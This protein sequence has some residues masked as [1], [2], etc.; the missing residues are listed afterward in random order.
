MSKYKRGTQAML[1]AAKNDA[2]LLPFNTVF[3]TKHIEGISQ[4]GM[5]SGV[6]VV[7]KNTAQ[8]NTNSVA[9]KSVEFE[10]DYWFCDYRDLLPTK[11]EKKPKQK[12]WQNGTQ[13]QLDA[14]KDDARLIP[15]KTYF[16]SNYGETKGMIVYKID[17]NANDQSDVL[18]FNFG[19]GVN[20]FMCAE[21]LEPVE[22]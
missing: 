16:Y 22:Y 1:D 15:K 21:E 17:S 19:T 11:K 13:S 10:G 7:R 2:T 6:T 5:P 18:M 3:I 14:A 8:C 12:K 4:V 9:F 20:Q